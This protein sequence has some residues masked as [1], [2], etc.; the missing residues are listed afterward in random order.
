[1]HTPVCNEAGMDARKT[2]VLRKAYLRRLHTSTPNIN[3]ALAA[4]ERSGAES[5]TNDIP[6]VVLMVRVL[7]LHESYL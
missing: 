5:V 4:E 3:R 6:P 1:M 7:V 2:L